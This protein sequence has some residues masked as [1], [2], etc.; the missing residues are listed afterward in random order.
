MS[1]DVTAYLGSVTLVDLL[2]RDITLLA[3]FV[4]DDLSVKIDR[5]DV[6]YFDPVRDQAGNPAIINDM[7]DLFRFEQS[8]NWNEYIIRR[9]YRQYRNDLLCTLVGVDTDTAAFFQTKRRQVVCDL[10]DLF[11]ELCI[12]VL[13]VAV[14]EPDLFRLT[15]CCD[16]Q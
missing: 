2:E 7:L 13:I 5:F 12:A 15:L 1:F 4:G 10:V 6:L 11:D 3:G 8:G 16:L 14:S 9:E